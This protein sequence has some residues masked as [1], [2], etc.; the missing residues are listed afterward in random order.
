MSAKGLL[1]GAAAAAAGSVA[2]S[3]T[4]SVASSASGSEDAAA[5][6]E[7]SAVRP[8]AAPPPAG[9]AA[10]G[11]PVALTSF[12][13]LVSARRKLV[14]EAGRCLGRRRPRPAPRLA[15]TGLPDQQRRQ[16][17]GPHAHQLPQD[18][19][20]VRPLMVSRTTPSVFYCSL[21]AVIDT[22]SFLVLALFA[23]TA[24]VEQRVTCQNMAL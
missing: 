11:N 14:S 9:P 19:A 13:K 5:A 8:A 6:A 16:R 2:A 23:T 10:L 17:A 1:A 15:R 24:R 22:N 3:A 18:P 4:G 20:H 12:S 7:A 21:F